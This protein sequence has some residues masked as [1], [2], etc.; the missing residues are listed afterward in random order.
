[1]TPELPTGNLDR[2][3]FLRLAGTSTAGLV[4]WRRRPATAF[5]PLAPLIGVLVDFVVAV[6]A[7]VVGSTIAEYL[8]TLRREEALRERILKT[9]ELLARRGFG[10]LRYS[11]VYGS[12]SSEQ[13]IYY[14]IV[15]SHCSCL[16]F[17]APF[18]RLGCGCEPVTMIQGPH[19]AGLALAAGRLRQ[20]WSPVEVAQH[21]IPI[22]G[23]RLSHGTPQDGYDGPLL[24]HSAEAQVRVE[25]R[26]TAPN[27]GVVAVWA[28][29]H[30]D[31]VAVVSDEWGLRFP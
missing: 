18:L 11:R 13:R 31:R 10:D 14:P 22:T 23:V 2:R 15:N 7:Q 20:R 28:H 9:N 5:L 27:A 25:Y 1:M 30:G 6:G 26:P 29:R 16:N 12:S 4:L 3:R 8:K 17:T 19:L 21:L 24:Y